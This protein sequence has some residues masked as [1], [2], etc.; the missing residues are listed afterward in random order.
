MFPGIEP[1]KIIPN[2]DLNEPFSLSGLTNTDQLPEGLINLY[3]TDARVDAR[4]VLFTGI[5][6]A[7]TASNVGSGI[8]LFKQKTGVDLEFKSLIATSTK[9]SLNNT[10]NEISINVIEANLGLNNIG[11]TL[12]SNK[13]GTGLTS[14]ASGDLIFASAT[15]TLSRLPINIIDGKVLTAIGGF[16]VWADAPTGGGGGSVTGG[17]NLSGGLGI[18]AGVSGSD[19][20]FKSLV[21]VTPSDKIVL[22]SDANTIK[23]DIDETK[24]TLNN[25]IGPLG[26][27]KGGTGLNALGTSGQVLTVNGTL[28]GLEWT[29]QIGESNAASNLVIDGGGVYG[30]FTV[31]TGIN[32]PFKS[33]SE[34]NGIS[35]N[36]NISGLLKISV[37]EP[38]LDINIIGGTPLDVDKGGTGL[39]SYA[40]GDLIFASAANTLSNR[41]IGTVGDVL[42]VVGGLPTWAPVPTIGTNP[43]V[44][45]WYKTPIPITYLDLSTGVVITSMFKHISLFTLP[46]AGVIHAIKIKHSSSFTGGSSTFYN[47]SIGII[48]DLTKYITPF[49]VFTVDSDDNFVIS[50]SFQ[51]ESHGFTTDIRISAESNDD[52]S[53][54]ISG[55]LD[56]WLLISR[57]P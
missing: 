57:A 20:K 40:S 39:T 3:Y 19:L 29:T 11:G 41:T 49:D 30:L 4:I 24:L 7:N 14:Y 31:K 33:L 27:S 47:I 37:Y 32:L 55:S 46:V 28:N 44:P 56:V 35:I 43:D 26:F 6:Q 1:E 54:I 50:N 53:N 15:N 5:G 34:D 45:T 16:P 22:T 17:I 25:M 9:I 38:E 12:L 2:Q 48:G 21:S 18:F 52:L 13:G 10:G 51:S 42:T 36:G 8:G 23:F